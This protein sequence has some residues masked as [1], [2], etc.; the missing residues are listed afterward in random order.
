[1]HSYAALFSIKLVLYQTNNIFYLE[2]YSF[3]KKK[4]KKK[5]IMYSESPSKIKVALLAVNTF[6][7][8]VYV[9][10]YFDLKSFAWKRDWTISRNKQM[11]RLWADY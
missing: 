4:K 6:P 5:M 10:S 3:S 8:Y 11:V 2:K 7:N 9:S 1:M